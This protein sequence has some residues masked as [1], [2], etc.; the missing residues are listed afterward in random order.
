MISVT[1]E[2][3]RTV[4]VTGATSGIGQSIA[5][6]FARAGEKVLALG[7]GEL[8]LEEPNLNYGEL[9]V[10]DAAAV[11]AALTAHDKLRVLVNCA[12]IIRVR[13]SMTRRFFSR[14]SIS[15]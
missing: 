10:Q 3:P 15:T 11:K 14:S 2:T 8:P 4:V 6:G 5:R 12:G 7:V 1:A 13:L 9:D